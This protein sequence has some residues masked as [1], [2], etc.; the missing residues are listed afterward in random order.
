MPTPALKKDYESLIKT[1]YLLDNP[2]ELQRLCLKTYRLL[3]Q[4]EPLSLR[5]LAEGAGVSQ[6]T[7][8]ELFTFLPKSALEYD[9]EGN[10]SALIGFSL[11][12][13]GHR[14]VVGEKTFYTW[15]ALDALFL[16]EI[17]AVTAA[18]LSRCPETGE[19]IRVTVGPDKIH[20]H[21]PGSVIVSIP[22]PASDDYT[23]DMRGA[24]CCHSNFFRDRTAFEAWAGTR[25]G[26]SGLSLAEAHRLAGKRNRW[27]FPD[28]EF[29]E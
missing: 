22:A 17:L 15:C 8:L 16:P 9:R 14:F 24:F 2:I 12:P 3:L 23:E 4:G 19:E 27:R 26:V 10:L 28:I 18:V 1:G 7:A 11:T 6:K 25:A 20:D 5:R 29:Q 13:A 21:A